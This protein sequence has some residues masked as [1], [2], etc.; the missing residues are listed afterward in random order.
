[1]EFKIIAKPMK[2]T[3]KNKNIEFVWVIAT[4]DDGGRKKNKIK[5]Q[6]KQITKTNHVISGVIQHACN[7]VCSVAQGQATANFKLVNKNNS[8]NNYKLCIP[9]SVLFF[10]V[11]YEIFFAM[12]CRHTLRRYELTDKLCLCCSDTCYL[13]YWRRNALNAW[14]ILNG[15]AA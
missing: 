12:I 3:G 15:I 2:P 7:T 6:Q 10:V 5:A 13:K 8:N 1:M 9:K 14:R 4:L 11:F